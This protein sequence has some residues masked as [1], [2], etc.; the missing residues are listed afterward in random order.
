MRFYFFKTINALNKEDREREK[1]KIDVQLFII[2]FNC[3]SAPFM[4]L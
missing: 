1:N 4:T 2:I 3:L